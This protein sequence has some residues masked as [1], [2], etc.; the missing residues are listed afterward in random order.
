MKVVPMNIK[1]IPEGSIVE[2]LGRHMTDLIPKLR[3]LG[4]PTNAMNVRAG[5]IN[6]NPDSGINI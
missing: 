4:I 3:E 1:E 2:G 6:N 5:R